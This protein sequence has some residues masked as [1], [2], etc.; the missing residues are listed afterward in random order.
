[1]MQAAAEDQFLKFLI[2]Q[3]SKLALIAR[4]THGEY[5]IDDV[6]HEAWLL[7]QELREKG[8]PVGFEHAN[9]ECLFSDQ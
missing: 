7:A 5:S 6:R 4:H 1:M 2:E 9:F 3:R 8:Q